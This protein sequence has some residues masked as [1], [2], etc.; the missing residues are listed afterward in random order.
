MVPNAQLTYGLED[1]RIGLM[2]VQVQR[3]VTPPVTKRGDAKWAN[4]WHRSI[5]VHQG[6]SI[7]LGVDGRVVMVMAVVVAVEIHVVAWN[8]SAVCTVRSR[9]C[10][11]IALLTSVPTCNV[12]QSGMGSPP[13]PT[14]K[15]EEE[16]GS[17]TYK[18]TVRPTIALGD[19]WST[20]Y[21]RRL[22]CC[23]GNSILWYQVQLTCVSVRAYNL[24]VTFHVSCFSRSG[25]STHNEL[26]SGCKILMGRSTSNTCSSSTTRGTLLR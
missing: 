1:Q 20:L 23:L 22:N 11:R 4:Q 17:E 12:G 18:D 13:P 15:K 8:T 19:L 2:T 10:I 9:Q 6:N 14:Q 24:S 26:V 16:G 5:F 7:Q 25:I 3:A 21:A